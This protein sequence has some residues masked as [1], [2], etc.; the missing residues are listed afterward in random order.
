MIKLNANSVKTANDIIKAS[1]PGQRLHVA[2]NET[3]IGYYAATQQE[4]AAL[5]PA[6]ANRRLDYDEFRDKFPSNAKWWDTWEFARTN[7][8]AWKFMIRLAIED[9]GVILNSQRVADFLQ[10]LVTNGVLTNNQRNNILS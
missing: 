6:D 5:H 9:R 4:W 2:G 7:A 3:P 10:L 1:Y 8:D